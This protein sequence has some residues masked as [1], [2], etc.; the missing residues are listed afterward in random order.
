MNV[1]LSQLI[2]K[3]NPISHKIPKMGQYRLESEFQCLMA[4]AK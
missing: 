2:W 3:V 1:L 4:K